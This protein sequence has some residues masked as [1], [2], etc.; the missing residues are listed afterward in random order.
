MIKKEALIKASF[1][2][3]FSALVEMTGYGRNDGW[4]RSDRLNCRNDV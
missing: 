4:G 1:F 3:D 2:M